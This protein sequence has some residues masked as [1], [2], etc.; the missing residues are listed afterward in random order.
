MEGKQKILPDEKQKDILKVLRYRYNDQMIE[1]D[2]DFGK[3]SV[4]GLPRDDEYLRHLL[5]NILA[6]YEIG[7]RL[8]TAAIA[9]ID[10]SS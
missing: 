5:A 4:H 2:A 8:A 6:E 3:V 7:I 10:A 1:W 9:M